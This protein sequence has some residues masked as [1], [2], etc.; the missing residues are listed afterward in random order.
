[1]GD[2]TMAEGT[3][4]ITPELREKVLDELRATAEGEVGGKGN[5]QDA[6]ADGMREVTYGF[7]GEDG[8]CA[9]GRTRAWW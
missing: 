9:L 8:F 2:R 7:D 3:G 5:G 6:D 1:M 4:T